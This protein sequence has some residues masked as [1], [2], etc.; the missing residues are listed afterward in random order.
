VV[1]LEQEVRVGGGLRGEV[2]HRGGRDQPTRRDLRDILSLAAGHPVHRRV[3]VG[4]GVLPGGDV[5]P[6]PARAALV[7]PADLLEP[8]RP[9]VP[10]R[11]GQH[12]DRRALLQRRGQVDH[13]DP[14]VR[15]RREQLVEHGHASS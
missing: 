3:E 2:Q 4:A 9:G 10:E 13:L 12:Q 15:H 7:V 11:L 8:E 5:V 14:A 6:V 1:D